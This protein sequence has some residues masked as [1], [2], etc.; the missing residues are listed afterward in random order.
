MEL[1]AAS[2]SSI[3]N[4]DF[5]DWYD[6]NIH[7]AKATADRVDRDLA[8]FA[9]QSGAGRLAYYK[10][11]VKEKQS[12]LDKITRFRDRPDAQIEIQKRFGDR[13]FHPQDIIR[14]LVGARM[15]FFF[16]P[17]R[18]LAY[19]YFHTYP[20]FRVEEIELY[21]ML[22]ET[23]T[24]VD[25]NVRTLLQLIRTGGQTVNPIPKDS[26]YESMH[27]TLRYNVGFLKIRPEDGMAGGDIK[28]FD[29]FP[30][31]LQVRTM[32]QDTWAQVE[33]TL[34]YADRKRPYSERNP[35]A[36]AEDFRTQKMIAKAC[37][38]YQ[39]TIWRRYRRLQEA[40]VQLT[41]TSQDLGQRL[42]EFNPEDAEMINCLNTRLRETNPSE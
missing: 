2:L 25:E 38:R 37:E 3:S 16:E 19:V 4:D 35:A 18:E 27:I 31:E 41:G 15:I 12:F 11:R 28:R 40:R 39:N 23:S 14:D 7:L 6:R 13:L 9:R 42:R 5:A 32:L 22:P 36:L 20:T 1:S 8:G 24:L 26:G 21:E 10:V 34:S 17:D 29:E 30:I 33:H